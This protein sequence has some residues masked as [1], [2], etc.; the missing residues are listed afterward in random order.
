MAKGN[1]TRTVIEGLVR[2]SKT[3]KVLRVMKAQKPGRGRP[4][5]VI[6]T[7]K[8]HYE[9]LK[10][11]DHRNSPVKETSREVIE[12]LTRTDKNGQ[13]LRVMKTQ[14]PGR[15]RPSIEVE[16]G[17]GQYELLRVWDY[18]NRPAKKRGRP[19][20]ADAAHQSNAA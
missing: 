11:W 14:K 16:V 5:V 10:Q 1:V 19:S 6:E 3:G 15:G 9:P 4:S 7:S 8:G 17:E 18:Q 12:G 20:K 2:T 13:V